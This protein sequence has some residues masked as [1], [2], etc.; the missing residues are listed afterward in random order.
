MSEEPVSDKDRSTLSFIE[1][2]NNFLKTGVMASTYKAVFLRSLVDIGRYN[3]KDLIGKQWIHREGNRIKLDLDFIAVRFAKY[4]WDMEIAF[5][6]RHMPERMADHNHPKR[7]VLIIRLIQKKVGDMRRRNGMNV[8]NNM[9]LDVLNNPSQASQEMKSAL[10]PPDPPTMKDLASD[11]MKEFRKDVIKH[12]IKPEVLVKLKKDMPDLYQIVRG[13]NY[14][15][16]DVEIVKFMKEFSPVIK[17]TLNYVLAVHLEKHNP[18]A[19]HIATKITD[20]EGLDVILQRVKRL[21]MRVEHKPAEKP[22]MNE[23]ANLHVLKHE[24]KT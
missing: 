5:K 24:Q 15:M 23:S 4:Y 10:Q 6:M 11:E 21:E 18:S 13:E 2:F 12:T 16:L 8:L 22:S 14:I 9:S 19:R 17:K 7:D 3:D 20:E 1:M